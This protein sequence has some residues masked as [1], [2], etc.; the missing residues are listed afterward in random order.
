MSIPGLGLTFYFQVRLAGKVIALPDDTGV[1]A[2]V[3]HL[4]V[5]DGQSKEIFVNL[6]GKLGAAVA[7]LKD[8]VQ[9]N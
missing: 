7:F 3:R 8:T 1:P 2:T 9:Q 5:L 4:R 6:D